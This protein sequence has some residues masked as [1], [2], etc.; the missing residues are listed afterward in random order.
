MS[1][2]HCNTCLNF[3]TGNVK[4]PSKIEFEEASSLRKSATGDK[5]MDETVLKI[6]QKVQEVSPVKLFTVSNCSANHVNVI[7]PIMWKDSW[8]MY[9]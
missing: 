2:I 5:V 3:I 8:S 1:E 7:D 9:R 6:R 4:G